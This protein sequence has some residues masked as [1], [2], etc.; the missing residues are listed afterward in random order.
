MVLVDSQKRNI[1][2]TLPKLSISKGRIY[3][4]KKLEKNNSLTIK[5]NFGNLEEYNELV[6]VSCNLGLPFAR[7]YSSGNQ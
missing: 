7:I 5:T 6:L 2:I 4:L 3:F 1:T